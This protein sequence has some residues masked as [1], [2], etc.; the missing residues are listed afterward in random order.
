MTVYYEAD[1][2][3]KDGFPPPS[4]WATEEKH[5]CQPKTTSQSQEEG[6]KTVNQLMCLLLD[7]L[8]VE[9]NLPLY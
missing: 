3:W 1:N 5:Y 6:P 2:L 7:M 9:N 4:R 8:M